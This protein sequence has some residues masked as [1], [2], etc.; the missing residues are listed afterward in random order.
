[1]P[2]GNTLICEGYDGRLFEVTTKGQVVWEYVSPFF[3]NEPDGYANRVFRTHRY[4]PDHTALQGK[5]L[6]PGRYANLNRVY[7]GG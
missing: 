5:E 7:G 2:N 6:D 3:R 1:L 4:G